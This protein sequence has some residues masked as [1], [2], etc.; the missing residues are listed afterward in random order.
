MKS[1][2]KKFDKVQWKINNREKVL[3]WHK[4]NHLL[5]KEEINRKRRIEYANNKEKY[6]QR[7]SNYY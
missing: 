6:K 1:E 2:K 5:K 4:Q 3:L 7:H